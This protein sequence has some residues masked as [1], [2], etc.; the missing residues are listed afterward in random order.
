MIKVTFIAY[1]QCA[2]SGILG[3]MD[4]FIIANLWNLNIRK[5]YSSSPSSL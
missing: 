3:L 4:A 1:E 2:L 5:D